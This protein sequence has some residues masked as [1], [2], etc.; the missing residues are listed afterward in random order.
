MQTNNTI[1]VNNPATGTLIAEVKSYSV[2]EGITALKKSKIAQTKWAALPIKERI[3]FLKKFQH[4]LVEAAEELCELLAKENGKPVGEAMIMEVLPVVDLT[5]YFCKKAPKI[6]KNKKISMHL[7]KYRKSY[8]HYKP[9]GVVYVIS[10]W[11]F[12][13]A[14]PTGEII[15]ALIAGNSVIH[16]PASITP[17]IALKTREL[18]L[19]TGID[20]DLYQVLPMSGAEAFQL[21]REG[22]DYVNFTGSTSVGEKVAAECGRLFIPCSMELGGKDPAIVCEDAHI[23]HAA[24]SLVWGAFANAG[25]VCASVERAYVHASIYDQVVEKVVA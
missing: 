9:K 12:P 22:V 3:V 21:I 8:I 6:L 24:E 17:L 4:L 15:M 2:S 13:F 7:V 16:K 1:A 10:P 14:I 25:Q 23:D 5:A 18:L 11:N 19:K 20:P